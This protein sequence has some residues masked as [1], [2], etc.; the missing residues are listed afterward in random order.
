MNP[1][2]YAKK[3]MDQV[4]SPHEDPLYCD[5]CEKVIREKDAEWNDDTPYC[6]DCWEWLC[7]YS[8]AM[9]DAAEEQRAERAGAEK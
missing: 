4:Y 8:D 2:E 6:K 9:A 5:R 3:V 1:I 7:A